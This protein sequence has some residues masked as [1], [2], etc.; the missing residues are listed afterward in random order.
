MNPS[1]PDAGGATLIRLMPAS[2]VT[3]IGSPNSAQAITAV[4]GGTRYIRL[5]TLDAAPR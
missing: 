5:A 1:S 4:V 2:V 3:P